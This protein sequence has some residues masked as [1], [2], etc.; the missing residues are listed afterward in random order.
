MMNLRLQPSAG[1][2]YLPSTPDHM[3]MKTNEYLFNA[4]NSNTALVTGLGFEF[5]RGKE[6]IL[7]VGLHYTKGLGNNET[8]LTTPA[9][10]GKLVTNT[11]RSTS[12]AWGITV[13]VPFTLKKQAQKVKKE[14]KVSCQERYQ[15]RSRCVKRI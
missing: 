4:G 14:Q 8:V 1:L 11:F 7:T 15:Y 3:V 6:R 10:N 2:A 13:G 9:E 12:S 5:G